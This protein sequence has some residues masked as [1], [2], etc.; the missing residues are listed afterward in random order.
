MPAKNKPKVG[1]KRGSPIKAYR[2]NS[3]TKE[4][5]IPATASR[6]AGEYAPRTYFKKPSKR[7][8]K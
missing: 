5:R 3:R 2:G 6:Y 1:R 4:G 8:K 7:R